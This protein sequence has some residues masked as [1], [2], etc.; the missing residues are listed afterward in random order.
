MIIDSRL[1]P[2]YFD[3]VSVDENIDVIKA[4]LSEADRENGV[5]SIKAV[6]VSPY[7]A[8]RHGAEVSE[9]FNGAILEKV[10]DQSGKVAL[11]LFVT[12]AGTH[13]LERDGEGKT[14]AAEDTEE[15]YEFNE[16]GVLTRAVKRIVRVDYARGGEV[17]VTDLGDIEDAEA[18]A[19]VRKRDVTM[20][21]DSTF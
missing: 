1:T 8:R 18:M 9:D 21:L 17:S 5:I 6:G 14:L 4:G 13:N 2:T 20:S 12:L 10:I 15:A 7:S 16:E 11:R 3:A 19:A